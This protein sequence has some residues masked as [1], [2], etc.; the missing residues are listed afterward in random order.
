MRADEAVLRLMMGYILLDRVS[1]I[2]RVSST[3]V[4][5]EL[6]GSGEDQLVLV[7]RW[8]VLLTV[9]TLCNNTIHHV[10]LSILDLSDL[11]G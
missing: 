6:G 8:Y 7:V 1:I 2:S 4:K 11:A 5:G 3:G 10:Y 9:T